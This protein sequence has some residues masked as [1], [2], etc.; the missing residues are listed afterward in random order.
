MRGDRARQQLIVSWRIHAA[1]LLIITLIEMVL[2]FGRIYLDSTV[3]IQ[4]ATTG[5]SPFRGV[6]IR[7]MLPFVA[8]AVW[9]LTGYSSSLPALS[10]IISLINCLFWAGA[11]VVSY[12]IGSLLR[13]RTTGFF[14]A[15]FFTTSVPVLAYGS[16]VLTDMSGYFFAGLA[17]LILLADRG[18]SLL[19]V[20]TEGAVLA[21]GGFFHPTAFLGL[22][23]TLVRRLFKG[24]ALETLEG[25]AL[26]LV[27]V[28]LIAFVGGWFRRGLPFV[29]ALFPPYHLAQGPRFDQALLYTFGILGLGY[30]GVGLERRLPGPGI[31]VLTFALFALVAI[32]GIHAVPKKRIVLAYL[33]LMALPTIV[34]ARLIE[35]Y[36]FYMWPS[37]LPVLV[38]GLR[39]LMEVPNQLL[40]VAA[41]HGFQLRS[42]KMLTERIANHK[43]LCVGF[44]LS[45]VAVLNTFSVLGFLG[46]SP[47]LR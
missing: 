41:L 7:F 47:F 3:Y 29:S 38:L 33:L 20:V 2:N 17:L 8:S 44:C 43:D 37:M 12:G 23:F 34:G 40:S 24:R 6:M 15:L 11:V 22:S 36:L 21:V 46:L 19:K 4:L 45:V 42:L 18:V 1:I 39:R 27:P 10:I 31:P 30:L 5:T 16:A 13:D 9:K 32:L 35:R 14:T 25:S 26:I 28:G